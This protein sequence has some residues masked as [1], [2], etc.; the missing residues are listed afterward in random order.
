MKIKI[1]AEKQVDSF[2]QAV[3]CL[4][5]SSAAAIQTAL[6]GVN[7]RAEAFT[8]RHADHVRWL[9]LHAENYLSDR[10]VPMSDR[11]RGACVGWTERRA[12]FVG[13]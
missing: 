2:G 6:D 12:A 4:T 9:A 11:R 10:N 7:G 13:G 5:A 3:S 8:V 1:E